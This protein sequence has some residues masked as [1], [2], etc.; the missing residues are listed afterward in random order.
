MKKLSLALISAALMLSNQSAIAETWTSSLAHC[1]KTSGP[2]DIHQ[3]DLINYNRVSVV[4]D[5]N[6]GISFSCPVELRSDK[7]ITKIQVDVSVDTA[8]DVINLTPDDPNFTYSFPGCSLWISYN[9]GGSDLVT[10]QAE[11]SVP[12]GN[13]NRLVVNNPTLQ[14]PGSG[15]AN[16][17]V[18]KCHTAYYTDETRFQGLRITYAD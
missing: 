9:P 2:T 3:G 1:Q 4:N 12:W 8:S 13:Y 15:Y 18:L 11:K 10:L 7:A 17:A 16:N 6:T 14:H 5:A